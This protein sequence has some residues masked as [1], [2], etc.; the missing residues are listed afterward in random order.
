MTRSPWPWVRSLG[1]C[2]GVLSRAAVATAVLAVASVLGW[3]LGDQRS[4]RRLA[5]LIQAAAKTR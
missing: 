5:S 2:Y 3:W 4:E 1:V